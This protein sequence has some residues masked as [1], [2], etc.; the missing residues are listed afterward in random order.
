MHRSAHAGQPLAAAGAGHPD[1]APAA[2]RPS[3]ANGVTGSEIRTYRWQPAD[4]K[5][6]AV[7]GG[8]VKPGEQVTTLVGER[9]TVPT[10]RLGPTEWTWPTCVRCWDEAK[11]CTHI[12]LAGLGVRYDVDTKAAQHPDK[13]RSA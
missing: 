8:R 1:S 13:R 3:E 5:R 10:Q 4:G 7:P 6:H 2:A 9:V 12:S 11:T